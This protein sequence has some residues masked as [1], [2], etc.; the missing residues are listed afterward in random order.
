MSHCVERSPEELQREK[1]ETKRT[2]IRKVTAETNSCSA[3]I[4]VLLNI[5]PPRF[6]AKC[7]KRVTVVF[8]VSSCLGL[9][10]CMSPL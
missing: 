10:S 2:L 7:H 5:M 9:L 1:E 8:D 6:L 3:A 4:F